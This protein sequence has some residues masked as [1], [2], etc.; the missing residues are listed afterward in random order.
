MFTIILSLVLVLTAQSLTEKR[1][2]E[3]VLKLLNNI[4][5]RNMTAQLYFYKANAYF[6]LAN[7]KETLKNLDKMN[8]FFMVDLRYACL[9]MMMRKD[10]STWKDNDLD[11]AQRLAKSAAR[12]LDLHRANGQTQ[13]DQKKIVDILDK[14][15]KQMED[16][17]AAANAAARDSQDRGKGN[18]NAT[19]QTDSHIA[20]DSGPG[21]VAEK[22][23]KEI[24]ERWGQ[25]PPKERA[26]AMT[27]L[28]KDLP[29]RYREIIENY[30]KVLTKGK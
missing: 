23:L 16:A 22:K 29:P 21:K 17:I 7:K 8:D 10:M 6:E 3:G 15:I 20:D 14:K 18:G 9:D 30:S 19:P 5:S 25:M 12:R 13:G 4:P 2:A 26:A 27:E 28:A 11:E 24:A 1:D